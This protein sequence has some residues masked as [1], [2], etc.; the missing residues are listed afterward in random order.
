[1]M[2]YTGLRKYWS[3]NFNF[4]DFEPKCLFIFTVLSEMSS[5]TNMLKNHGKDF[6]L[7]TYKTKR[8]SD[9]KKYLAEQ[10]KKKHCI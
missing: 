8:K 10:K 4:H 9:L 3:L 1:M 5:I 2:F 7:N 6:Y